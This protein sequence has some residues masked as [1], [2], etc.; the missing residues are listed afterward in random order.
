MIEYAYRYE[1]CSSVQSAEAGSRIHLAAMRYGE[2]QAFFSAALREAR[3]AA[4]WMLGLAQVVNTR[5]YVPPAMVARRLAAADPVI[6]CGAERLRLEGFSP[7]C[8]AYA[9][10]DLLPGAYEATRAEAG[11]TNVDFRPEMRAALAGVRHGEAARLTVSAEEVEFS[12]GSGSAVERKVRLPVRWLKGFAEVQAHQARMKPRFTL[13]GAMAQRFLRELPR[14]TTRGDV[15]VTP[16]G[17]AVRMSRSAMPGAVRVGGIERLRILAPL[18]RQAQSLTVYAG[19]DGATAWQLTRA[20][21]RF[22]LALSPQANRGFSGEG[23]VLFPLAAEPARKAL[24]AVR[25]ALRWQS[26]IAPEALGAEL[27]LGEDE[28][29]WALAQLGVS[30]LVGYDLAEG[31]YFHRELPFDFSLIEEM[32]PRLKEARRLAAESGVR[33][34]GEEAWVRGREVEHR[35]RKVDGVWRCTCPWIARHGLGRGPC[36]HILAVEMDGGEGDG[37]D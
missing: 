21:M 22:L 30:G 37:S 31:A 25:A 36:K 35:V 11:T 34:E 28:A 24:G 4:D 14:T 13:S 18:A 12:T 5:F 23:Q 17:A 15:W 8:G 9:R 32:Q 19:E 3:C 20:E 29:A 2:R 26:R 6:T 27:G 16:V 10:V 33:W 7:C 1:H